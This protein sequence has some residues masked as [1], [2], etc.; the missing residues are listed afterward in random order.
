MEKDFNPLDAM[1]ELY[2]SY[3]KAINSG[4]APDFSELQYMFMEG[5]Y[6]LSVIDL[7]TAMKIA[8]HGL[9]QYPNSFLLKSS[10]AIKYTISGLC[11]KARA[12]VLELDVTR[13]DC[14]Q[15]LM[16]KGAYLVKTGS[17]EEGIACMQSVIDSA[18]DE[19][20][21]I[22]A[23]TELDIHTDPD[24]C[25]TRAIR[26]TGEILAECGQPEKA[27]PFLE[28]AMAMTK[29]DNVI[30]MSLAA[31]YIQLGNTDK[32]IEVYDRI[33]E[34][35]PYYIHAWIALADLYFRLGDFD[36]SIDACKYALTIKKDHYQALFMQSRAYAGKWDYDGAM[37][38]LDVLCAVE[39]KMLDKDVFFMHLCEVYTAVQDWEKMEIYGKKFIEL[40]PEVPFGWFY[41][42][43]A[44]IN[45][46][47]WEEA[48]PFIEKA[49][50][51]NPDSEDF[52][53]YYGMA[54]M[55][56]DRREKAIDPLER[57]LELYPDSQYKQYAYIHL[58][59]AHNA[60]TGHEGKAREYRKKANE[61]DPTLIDPFEEDAV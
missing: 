33:L 17:V 8:E 56:T 18:E 11:D 20:T 28:E 14:A 54:C 26:D 37:E 51:F 30:Q 53:F 16:A 7:D 15:T 39:D 58:A 3:Y 40:E 27:I 10:L 44:I 29:C 24:D 4:N 59:N 23:L 48:I 25:R 46:L 60:L 57:M 36:N 55:N 19:A 61:I 32:A 31:C 35:S 52:M 6:N 34:K 21:R 13:P 43:N 41:T 42:A 5:G 1:E 47:R 9:K 49:L 2:K 45:Q 38:G 12:L 22:N 50:E